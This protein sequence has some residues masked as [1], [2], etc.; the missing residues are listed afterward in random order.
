MKN[1][2][3]VCSL[4]V[5]LL[6]GNLNAQESESFKHHQVVVTIGHASLPTHEEGEGSKEYLAVPTWGLSY[7]FDFN[8]RIGLGVKSDIEL[9]NYLLKDK[10]DQVLVRNY[11]VSVILIGKYNPIEGLGMYVGGGAE[12]SNEEKLSIFSV[13]LTYDVDF[14]KVW[15]LSPELG[16]ELKGGHTNVFTIGLSVGLRMGKG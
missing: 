13:G 6:N 7:E 15:I 16:Y 8:K 12:L 1:S 11:P 4:L 2:L 14:K 10:E 5:F 3:I 9:S